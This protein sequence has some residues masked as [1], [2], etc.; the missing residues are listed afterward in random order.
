MKNRKRK[1][2]RW[3]NR[4]LKIVT[5]ILILL[6]LFNLAKDYNTYLTSFQKTLDD[7]N[8]RIHKLEQ[9]VVNLKLQNQIYAR[10]LASHEKRLD[11]LHMPKTEVQY[12][13]TQNTYK[14]NR[15]TV[16]NDVYSFDFVKYGWYMIAI[17][18]LAILRRIL[19]P[20]F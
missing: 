11:Q 13:P 7:N 4:L 15:V 8:Q 19:V 1:D 9:E 18:G 2:N 12:A 14:E 10:V 16:N 3:L 6:L 20:I 5:L 17:G